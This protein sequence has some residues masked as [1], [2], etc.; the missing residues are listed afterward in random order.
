MSRN[1]RNR[2]HSLLSAGILQS[3]L[4]YFDSA[5]PIP[6][7]EICSHPYAAWLGQRSERPFKNLP[8]QKIAP[9]IHYIIRYKQKDGYLIALPEFVRYQGP[10]YRIRDGSYAFKFNVSFII[11]RGG[12]H[13]LL[14]NRAARWLLKKGFI[15]PLDSTMLFPQNPLIPIP[16]T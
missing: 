1:I 16:G 5:G 15:S 7:L 13:L 6:D 9:C 8:L 12:F 2:R 10:S 3:D 11:D 4:F 14:S